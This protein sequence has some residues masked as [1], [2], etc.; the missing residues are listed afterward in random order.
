MSCAKAGLMGRRQGVRCFRRVRH[1]TAAGRTAG[2]RI[3]AVTSYAV[4]LPLSYPPKDP[5]GLACADCS[6]R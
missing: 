5:G 6:I 3:A 1:T 2:G 4:A